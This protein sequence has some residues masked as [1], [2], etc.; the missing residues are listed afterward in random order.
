MLSKRDCLVLMYLRQ[1]KIISAIRNHS[2][3][4]GGGARGFLGLPRP[5]S[6][7]GALYAGSFSL[8]IHPAFMLYDTYLFLRVCYI[9]IKH[10]KKR[11]V[12]VWSN[13]I[14]RTTVLLTMSWERLPWP[15][16]VAHAAT[17]LCVPARV[18]SPLHFS[19]FMGP[20][21]KNIQKGSLAKPTWML[22][23]EGILNR[24]NAHKGKKCDFNLKCSVLADPQGLVKLRHPPF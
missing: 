4:C 24:R 14:L 6:W 8:Q 15:A 13:I 12:P 22:A 1:K 23:I 7:S 17:W 2:S 3:R 9:L 5:V 21:S 20:V 18:T 16:A 11:P 19:F 10:F